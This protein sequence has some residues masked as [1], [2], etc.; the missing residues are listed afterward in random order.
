M[1]SFQLAVSSS[2]LAISRSSS[3][4][5]MGSEDAFQAAAWNGKTAFANCR[6]FLRNAFIA[7]LCVEK[8][9]RSWRAQEWNRAPLGSYS[10]ANIPSCIV[11]HVDVS[12]LLRWLDEAERLHGG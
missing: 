8:L 9:W 7:M 2:F 12:A 4:R 3:M 1:L 11:H 10:R 5:R 6:V